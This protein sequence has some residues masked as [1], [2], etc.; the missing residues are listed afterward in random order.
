MTPGRLFYLGCH[1]PLAAVAHS[2]RAGGPLQ[3]WRNFRGEAAMRAAATRLPPTPPFRLSTP[4]SP[5]ICFLTG[6]RFWHQTAFCAWSFLRAAGRP[7]PFV[8]YDDGTFDSALVTRAQQLFPGCKIVSASDSEA[9]LDTH[10]PAARFPSLRAQ[11]RSYLHLRKLTDCHAGH[12]GVRLVLD[13]DILFFRRPDAVLAWL[14]APAEPIHL[15]DVADAYGYP[16]ATLQTLSRSPIPHRVN[17]GLL[18]LRSDTIDWAKLEHACTTL[19]VAHGTSYYLEQALCAVLLAEQTAI[20]LPFADYR[21]MPDETE[22]RRP[23]ATLHHYVAGS[24]RGYFRH[25]WRHF[26]DRT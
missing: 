2:I 8:F 9:A 16:A 24:K 13:S 7:V 19:L 25:A 18:G 15:I 22:C 6:R 3:Q 20:R 11:R 21:L 1:A 5:E 26:G 17:V 23:T 4:L 10:L 12:T 14:A